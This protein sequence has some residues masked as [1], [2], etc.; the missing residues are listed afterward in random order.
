MVIMG[1]CLF[2][3]CG[4]LLVF[5]VFMMVVVVLG[6]VCSG[7]CC[8]IV[9]LIMLVWIRCVGCCGWLRRSMVRSFYGW[10]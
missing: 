6:V 1:C 9:G 3:W 10:I 4:M 7:L 2:G 8:L 5:I